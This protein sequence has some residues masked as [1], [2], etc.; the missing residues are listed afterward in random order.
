MAKSSCVKNKDQVRRALARFVLWA[1]VGCFALSGVVWSEQQFEHFLLSDPRFILPP[2]ADIGQDSP[3]L[4]IEGVLFAN[5]AQIVR[6]FANDLG[7]S[8]Y[9]LPLADRRKALLRLSWV[10]DDTVVRLWPNRIEVHITERRPVAFVDIGTEC[11]SR[12]SLIDGDGVILEP[13]ERN[14][15]F[16]L[17]TITGVRLGEK[18]AVRSARVG[19]MPALLK[20]LGP[21]ADSVSRSDVPDLEHLK[22]TVPMQDRAI[23]LILC[24]RNFHDRLQHCLH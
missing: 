7:R 1:L 10:K 3:N 13:P 8:V 15:R 9:M 11:I 12:Y 23:I 19:R 2:P 18:A 20:D 4:R 5:R 17:P 16:D 22:V 14:Y 21:L 24:D 6:V